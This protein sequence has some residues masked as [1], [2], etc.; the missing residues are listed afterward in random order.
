MTLKARGFHPQSLP[1]V[2]CDRDRNDHAFFRSLRTSVRRAPRALA[3]MLIAFACAA[4]EEGGIH[5]GIRGD[6]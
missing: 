3:Q 2:V 6:T 4:G 5:E 1:V